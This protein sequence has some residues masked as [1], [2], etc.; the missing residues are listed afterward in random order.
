[1]LPKI[2]VCGIDTADRIV[3]GT[4]T[5]IDEFPWATLIGYMNTKTNA[6][7]FFCGGVLIS[8]RYVLT[9]SHCVN[10][11]PPVWKL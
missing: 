5:K 3:G 8:D 2:G 6:T 9:A 11:I 10:Q 7:G 4:K 1:M